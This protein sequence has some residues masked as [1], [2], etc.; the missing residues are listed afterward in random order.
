M[1]I[2]YKTC[3][4]N[5]T[6]P[7]CIHRILTEKIWTKYNNDSLS[8]L[9]ICKLDRREVSPVRSIQKARLE[10]KRF[11]G[12]LLEVGVG[13]VHFSYQCDVLTMRFFIDV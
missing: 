4:K 11:V 7:S 13:D 5:P 12:L 8:F 3:D 6:N 9:F 10:L 1:C 2:L